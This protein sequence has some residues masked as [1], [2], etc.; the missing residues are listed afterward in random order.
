M[1]VVRSGCCRGV[2]VVVVIVVVIVAFFVVAGTATN[3]IDDELTGR[4][5]WHHRHELAKCSCQH[6][7]MDL[8]RSLHCLSIGRVSVFPQCTVLIRDKRTMIKVSVNNSISKG[9][10]LCLLKFNVFVS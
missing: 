7:R 10:A 3:F 4:V 9:L 2:V 5:L 8:L 6:N 1:L